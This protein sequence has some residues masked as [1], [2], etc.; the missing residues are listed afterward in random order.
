MDRRGHALE[1]PKADRGKDHTRRCD[2]LGWIAPS[3]LTSAEKTVR[4]GIASL[5]GCSLQQ[6]SVNDGHGNRDLYLLSPILLW[7]LFG[8]ISV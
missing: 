2:G 5:A 4:I 7:G 1:K 6:F 8:Q 3:R